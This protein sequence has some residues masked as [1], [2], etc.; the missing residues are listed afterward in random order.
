MDE[1]NRLVYN[2]MLTMD[3]LLSLQSEL[4]RCQK[5]EEEL[6][7]L[8]KETEAESIKSDISRMKKELTEIQATF[9]KET[10]EVIQSY[11][12]METTSCM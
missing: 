6:H 8:Q 11:M 7:S 10:E 9:E 3:K 2:Q 12:Q 4:E 1:F 5:I